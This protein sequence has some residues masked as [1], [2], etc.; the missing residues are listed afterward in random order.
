MPLTDLKIKQAKPKEKSY[1]I[2]D[3]RGLYIEIAPAGENGGDSN[4]G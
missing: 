2:A 4:I 3:E 1:K